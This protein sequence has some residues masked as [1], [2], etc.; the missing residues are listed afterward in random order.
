MAQVDLLRHVGVAG[1]KV[2]TGAADSALDMERRAVSRPAAAL[3][4]SLP[5]RV[6]E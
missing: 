4:S 2:A 6:F 5:F 1:W 3:L